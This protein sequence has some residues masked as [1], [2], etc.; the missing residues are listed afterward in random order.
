ME[1]DR[2]PLG[3]GRMRIFD[4][5][6]RSFQL[7]AFQVLAATVLTGAAMAQDTTLGNG[8]A[9]S[10]F[11]PPASGSGVDVSGTW[12]L[13]GNQDAGYGTAAGAL[14]DYGGL[15]FNEAGRLYALAWPANRQTLRVEQCAGYTIPYAFFSPGNY[16]FWEERDPHNQRLIAIHMYFQTSEVNR[17]IWMDGRPHPPA[18]AAHTFAGFST[19]EW[20][21]N[22]L[23]ITTT[24]MKHGYLRGD[25]SSQSDEAMVYEALVRHGDELT[26][27]A[28]TN[29]PVWLDGPT[30]KSIINVRNVVDPTAWLYACE[31]GEEIIA[32]SDTDVPFYKWGQHPF[33]WE[34]ADKNHVP[35]LGTLGGA[36]TTEPEFLAKL[37]NK[38][39]EEAEAMKEIVP[40]PGAP[41]QFNKQAAAEEPNDGQIHVL[42]VQGKVYMLV[43]DGGNIAVQVGDEGAFV[44]DAG[45]GKL[46]DKV[47]A[48]IAELSPGRPAQ[49]ILSTSLH[50]DHVGGN[51]KLGDSG[52]DPSLP[53]SFFSGNNQEIGTYATKLAQN[54]VLARMEAQGVLGNLVP[55]DTY[56]KERRRKWHN[57]EGIDMF[58]MP[59][60][61][62]DG[63]TIVHFRES[64]VMAVGDIVDMTRYPFIDLK[65]GGSVQGE[66]DALNNILGMTQYKH[67]ED[68]GTMIIPGHGRLCDEYD[69]GQYREMVTII[70]D[71]IQTAMKAGQTLDQIKKARLTADYDTRYGA[72][73]GDWT[74]DMFVEAV[75]NSLKQPIAAK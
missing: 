60:A 68:G 42:P 18:W 8:G 44:V 49:F 31:D 20:K 13:G 28:E 15:S 17:T 25:G 12:S 43:G 6:A 4:M 3:Q 47:I 33:L 41:P 59:N 5:R 75:Y 45:A 36:Q 40:V 14:V 51:G 58:Y 23:Y 26:Y 38:A 70:R 7:M 64:D 9:F 1:A 24:H 35:H 69:I 32:R 30:T 39:A 11:R 55:Q 71:R 27:F 10:N 2:V 72:V 52:Q 57:G 22:I 61:S 67:D 65:N 21:G 16:R 19:G 46:T 66:I 54:N 73:T 34:Y 62:T 56:L 37:S 63:D 53:G 50:P 48:A 74:T 29:D